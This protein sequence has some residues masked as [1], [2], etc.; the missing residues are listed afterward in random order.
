MA[1]TPRLLSLQSRKQELE[2]QIQDESMHPAYNVFR[3][4]ELKKRKLLIMD[5]MRRLNSAI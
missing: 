5:E 4:A 2:N 3:I 1:L